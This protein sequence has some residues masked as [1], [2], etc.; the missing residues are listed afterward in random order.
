M[1]NNKEI[2]K[3]I[4][5]AIENGLISTAELMQIIDNYN[6]KQGAIVSSPEGPIVK[7]PNIEE[8]K[9]L[10]EG[11]NEIEKARK[12]EGEGLNTNGGGAIVEIPEGPIVNN[13]SIE[14]I[15]VLKNI[16]KEI[17]TAE[18][19]EGESINPVYKTR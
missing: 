19:L 8:K 2:E 16:N 17:K 6:K 7:D 1:N 4:E 11:L 18:E 3:L 15:E 13:P 5:L 12:L 14:E 9:A 10:Q